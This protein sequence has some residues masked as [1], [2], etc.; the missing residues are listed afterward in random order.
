M[1]VFEE[2][3]RRIKERQIGL[4]TASEPRALYEIANELTLLRAEHKA[5]RMLI[6]SLAT[7]LG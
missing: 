7:Q 5:L 6:T 2:A 3:E 1:E 4:P